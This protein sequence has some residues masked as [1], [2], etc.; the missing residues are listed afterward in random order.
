MPEVLE[1]KETKEKTPE[2]TAQHS[3]QKT[4][5]VTPNVIAEK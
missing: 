1:C 3:D 5:V 2:P 4:A